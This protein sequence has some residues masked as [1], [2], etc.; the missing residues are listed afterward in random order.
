MV[1]LIFRDYISWL[2]TGAFALIQLRYFLMTRIKLSHAESFF[3]NKGWEIIRDENIAQIKISQSSSSFKKLIDELNDYILKNHGTTD[4]SI[5]QNKT[6]RRVGVIFNQALSTISFPT[7]LGLMGTFLGVFIGMLMFNSGIKAT[8]SENMP[9]DKLIDGMLISMATSFWGLL[10]TTINNAKAGDVR[11]KVDEAKGEFY[12]FL[13]NELLPHLGTS[14]VATLNSLRNTINLFEPAFKNVIS[15]FETTFTECTQKFSNT[16]AENVTLVTGAVR[17]MGQNMSLINE[18]VSR[19]EQLLHTLQQ[20]S[21]LNTL[22]RFVEAAN[23]FNTATHSIAK[24]D[25]VKNSIVNSTQ[26]LVSAQ[27][28]FNNSLIVP[29]EVLSK[30]NQ[31][32][33]RITTFEENINALG[34]TISQTQ[35]LGNTEMNLIEEHLRV[36]KTKTELA[37]QY[38]E[39]G[40][41]H[42]Q[43]LYDEQIRVINELNSRYKAAIEEHKDD[44]ERTM[45]E[46]ENSYVQIVSNCKAGVENKVNE[47]IQALEKGLD[48]EGLNDK[49]AYLS[50]LQ[51]MDD[52]LSNIKTIVEEREAIP[53]LRKIDD[54][55]AIA[56]VSLCEIKDKPIMNS[57][58]MKTGARKETPKRRNLFSRLFKR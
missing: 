20:S 8:G 12:A 33:N 25:E 44:F 19:Q 34:V 53:V 17:I 43:D 51:S 31:I 50:K 32:L 28:S 13:Q 38:Q 45:Q 9:I 2:V 22:E 23:C 56:N 26:Q 46:F 29:E 48:I 21:I 58:S 16:F 7:Y 54:R 5:I 40:D 30:I 35:L 57:N 11:K 39:T 36:L 18:N 1:D 41:S 27:T 3:A 42:L 15:D 6:E 10:L 55:L 4:F 14:V 24:L 49:L 37:I 47:F 52:S